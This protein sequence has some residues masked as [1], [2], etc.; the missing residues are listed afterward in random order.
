[1]ENLG[2]CYLAGEEVIHPR[3]PDF[4]Q[5]LAHAYDGRLLLRCLCRDPGIPVY[6]ARYRDYVV[7]RCPGTGHQHDPLCDAYE[8]P[9]SHGGLGELMGDAVRELEGDRLEVVFSFP[10]SRRQG[11]SRAAAE[12]AAPTHV[13][14]SHRP[15][16]LRAMLHLLMERAGFNRW[17]PR[18]AGKRNWPV[19]RYHLLQAATELRA[20]GLC[21]ADRLFLP[22]PFRREDL[23]GLAERRQR[24]LGTLM[25]PQGDGSLP[26]MLI[27]GEVKEVA[28]TP[29]GAALRLKHMA[30]VA[31]HV[32]ATT[33]CRL[34]RVFAEAIDAWELQP[35]SAVRGSARLRLLLAALVFAKRESLLWVH[36]ATLQLVNEQ[37]L[38]LAHPREAGLL[39][40]LVNEGRCFYKPLD[41]ESRRAPAFANALL[42]DAR[43]APVPLHIVSPLMPE[44]ERQ[45]KEEGI[46]LSVPSAWIWRLDEG[47]A[48]PQLPAR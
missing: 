14:S 19:F 41:F 26:M 48:A 34:R 31:L 35:A 11:S 3:Q 8:P 9:P 21:L 37:W 4:Q 40:M 20:K 13:R 22:E 17:S 10:L 42:L 1:M 25:V 39:Q 18:M 7:K 2:P 38:P 28:R 30:N 23:D 5:R 29:Q 16:G 12:P 6:I 36:S 45:M 46:K 15:L 27:V 44:H 24:R 47:A 43:P 32:D 33:L